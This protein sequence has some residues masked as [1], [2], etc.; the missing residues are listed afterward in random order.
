MKKTAAYD[1]KRRPIKKI[2]NSLLPFVSITCLF[3]L[4]FYA[5]NINPDLV[6]SPAST[7]ERLIQ[8]F[9]KPVNKMNLFGHVWASLQRVFIALAC[10]T[11]LGV[12]VGVM[13]GWSKTFKAIFGT[14]FELI[15]PIPP[16]A[17]LPIIIMWFG[18]GEF[19]K[20]LIVF[21]GTFMPIVVN[22]YTGIRLVMPLHLDV[23]RMFNASNRQLL[24]EV[25]IP[26]ALPPIFAGIRNATSSGWMTVLAA[27]MIA[28]KAGLGFLITRGMDYF[29]VPLILVGMLA[30]GIVGAL[31]AIITE[32]IERLLCPWNKKLEQD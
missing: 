16:I 11:V 28:S 2:L 17:W 24:F 15:R 25:A 19:P 26:S 10:A 12:T 18:I 13:I 4:W 1:Q 30:I 8:L 5:S 14:L 23:A 22:T 21:I 20:I 27:E 29:D 3:L 6:P 32:F 31:L 7:W 9:V